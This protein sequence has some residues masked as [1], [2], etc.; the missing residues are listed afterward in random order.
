MPA[1]FLV[2]AI[3]AAMAW[4]VWPERLDE[5]RKHLG[6]FFVAH[7]TRAFDRYTAVVEKQFAAASETTAGGWSST[8][9]VEVLDLAATALKRMGPSFPPI[10]G[11]ITLPPIAILAQ[12]LKVPA[13]KGKLWVRFSCFDVID[14]QHHGSGSAASSARSPEGRAHIDDYCG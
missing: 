13:V 14:I 8:P 4:A 12:D 7:K 9:R 10:G 5:C 1:A 3:P 11:P 2:V 6:E